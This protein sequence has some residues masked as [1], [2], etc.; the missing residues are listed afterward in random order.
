MQNEASPSN[1]ATGNAEPN[2]NV[3]LVRR[4]Y[5]AFGGGDIPSILALCTPDVEFSFE[6]GRPEIPW[7]GPWRGQAA[8]ARFFTHIG[9]AV[10]FQAFEPRHF[11]ASPSEVAVLVHLRYLVRATDRIVDQLQVHWWSLRDGKVSALRH[12][13]DT[14][15]V[16]AAV[17]R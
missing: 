7:H 15:Q 9:E 12:H 6:G 8:V 14:A 17:T 10:Q 16:L 13:E 4:I 11:A 1:D 2:R 5:E 3:V